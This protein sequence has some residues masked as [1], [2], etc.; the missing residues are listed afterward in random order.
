MVMTISP[1]LV[2]FMLWHGKRSDLDDLKS[3]GQETISIPVINFE[4]FKFVKSKRSHSDL[5]I[6]DEFSFFPDCQHPGN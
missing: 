6:F 2:H 3:S 4:F 1:S 5:Y